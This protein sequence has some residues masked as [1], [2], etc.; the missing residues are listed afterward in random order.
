MSQEML[1]ALGD[2]TR[3]ER[4]GAAERAALAAAVAITREPRGLP[5][6]V[7]KDLREHFDDG[8]IVEI[9][10]SIG[11]FNYFNRLNNALEV[12]PTTSGHAD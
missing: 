9:I 2:Y 1:D 7:W 10:C 11:L 8:Q 12:E 3:D 4:F 5:E 6:A